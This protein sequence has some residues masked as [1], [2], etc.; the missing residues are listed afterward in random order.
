MQEFIK[1][2]ILQIVVFLMVCLIAYMLIANP[3]GF[4]D[5][6]IREFALKAMLYSI[7]AI[8]AVLGYWWT[9][10]KQDER[11]ND[12]LFEERWNKTLDIKKDA[13]VEM[14]QI[15]ANIERILANN[16][17]Y[18]IFKFIED[19]DYRN[20]VAM[21]LRQHCDKIL[22]MAEMFLSDNEN[23]EVSTKALDINFKLLDME[24]C[25][26]RWLPIPNDDIEAEAAIADLAAAHL[27]AIIAVVY[28][29][30]WEIQCEAHGLVIQRY[31]I[32]RDDDEQFD[33]YLSKE[34]YIGWKKRAEKERKM[35]V[36][37]VSGRR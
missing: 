8:V 25:L 24:D 29:L 23:E 36:A 18:Y 1:D 5:I 6:E 32:N 30:R 34:E 14:C 27:K 15:R 9:Q 19:H 13:L 12:N 2:Y 37:E 3:L 20:D 4:S 16:I 31:D 10:I 35:I 7:T 26:S 33:G 17:R 22:D 28:E 21:E 11:H